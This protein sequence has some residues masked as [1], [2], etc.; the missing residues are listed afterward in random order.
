[1]LRDSVSR[2]RATVVRVA[3]S[4]TIGLITV[5]ISTACARDA[6]DPAPTG[7]PVEVSP[8]PTAD[9]AETDAAAKALVAYDGFQEA[10]IAAAANPGAVS[11]DLD[12]YA[13]S[14]LGLESSFALEKQAAS[15]IVVVGRPTWTAHVTAVNTKTPPY[16]VT[17]ENCF[18]QTNWKPIYKATG[19]SAAAPGQAPRYLITAK[20]ELYGDGSWLISTSEAHRDRPC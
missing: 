16:T 6:A 5:G 13:G 18:D 7:P 14:P 10:Y 17:I 19:K 8:S 12:K 15:G 2:L 1:M 20:A 3:V 9:A 11:K 4:M